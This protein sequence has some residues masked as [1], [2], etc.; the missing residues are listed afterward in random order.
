[1]HPSTGNGLPDLVAALGRGQ[2]DGIVDAAPFVDALSQGAVD[3]DPGPGTRYCGAAQLETVGLP[4]RFGLTDMGVGVAPRHP[5]LRDAL[6]FWIQALRSCNPTVKG[7]LCHNRVNVDDL[8]N[9]HVALGR[10]GAE[11]E[12]DDAA[13]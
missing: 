1:M 9:R 3:L 8:Y 6:S 12:L 10:C 5:E 2:C 11:H 7:E 4:L 13:R